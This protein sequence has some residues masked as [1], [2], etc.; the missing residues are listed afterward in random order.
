MTHHSEVYRLLLE[1]FK[2][3]PFT[4]VEI[5][6]FR[7][8]LPKGILSM[9]PNCTKLWTIDP[10]RHVDGVEFEASQPQEMHD[11]NRAHAYQCL[12]EFGDRA[13]ILHMT[14]DEAIKHFVKDV[15]EA[16]PTKEITP[17]DVVWVDGHHDGP[18]ITKDIGNYWPIVKSGGIFGGHD[19]GQCHPLSEIVAERFGDSIHTGADF[20]FWVYK[21]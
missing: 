11:N 16:V 19:Y 1:H 17:V 21:Y 4:F 9:F 14:S 10:W 18:S 2:S 7:A 8:D 15:P 12:K 3:K 6:T 20:T 13:Q 5:G